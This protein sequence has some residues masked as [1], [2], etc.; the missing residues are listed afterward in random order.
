MNKK[1]LS[2]YEQTFKAKN[3]LCLWKGLYDENYNATYEE[4]N[5]FQQISFYI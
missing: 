5:N 4:F 3:G 1:K 2:Y